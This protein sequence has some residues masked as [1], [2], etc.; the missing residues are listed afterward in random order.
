MAPCHTHTQT[1]NCNLIHDVRDR[2]KV[3]THYKYISINPVNA[4]KKCGD[5]KSR[6]WQKCARY[7]K[8]LYLGMVF[9]H[10]RHSAKTSNL[11]PMCLD[12]MWFAIQK[13]IKVMH[14]FIKCALAFDVLWFCLGVNIVSIHYT[15]RSRI[16][17]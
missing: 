1:H 15:L 2:I 3:N 9:S 17:R 12:C 14:M 11:W 10:W 13:P 6:K 16:C 5:G 8:N 4:G 7:K